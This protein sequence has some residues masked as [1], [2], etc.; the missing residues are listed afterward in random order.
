MQQGLSSAAAEGSE[1]ATARRGLAAGEVDASRGP[2]APMPP[3]AAEK[4]RSWGSIPVEK[5]PE[6]LGELV[7]KRLVAEGVPPINVAKGGSGQAGTG[8][9]AFRRGTWE[10]ALSDAYFTK[11]SLTEAE[12]WDMVDSA[13]HE[14][15]H[16]KQYWEAARWKAGDGTYRSAEEMAERLKLDPKMTRKAWDA[17]MAP[18]DPNAAFGKRMFESLFSEAALDVKAELGAAEEFLATAEKDLKSLPKDAPSG[19]RKVAEM[20]VQIGEERY[21]EALAKERVLPHEADAYES[22]GKVAKW[23]RQ[24]LAGNPRVRVAEEVVE[25][26]RVRV[27][28]ATEKTASL[29][30]QSA[31][32]DQIAEADLELRLAGD[33]LTKAE[34]KLAVVRQ[35][36][37]GGW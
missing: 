21:A 25:S 28:V 15:R 29:K 4:F 10:M 3:E 19:K 36:A 18:E 14:A 5:R 6:A 22:A 34:G 9:G 13:Y 23:G 30:L 31:S 35:D 1:A 37:R 7:N 27:R 33:D 26:V 12:F 16:A 11:E 32:A 17:K 8:A 24:G 20:A 2:K